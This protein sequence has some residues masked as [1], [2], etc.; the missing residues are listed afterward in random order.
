MQQIPSHA[1]D[2]RHQFRATPSMEKID[3]CNE[4]DNGIEV[5]LGTYDTVFMADGTEKEVIDLQVGDIV[6]LQ[7]NN[8]EVKAIVRS[9]SHQ[10]PDT[11]LC[12]TV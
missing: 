11:C 8:Q 4:T 6:M 12:F 2:I 5:T 9:I 1:N 3:D 7:N 10:T